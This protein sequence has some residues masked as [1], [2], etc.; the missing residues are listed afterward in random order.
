MVVV[1][2]YK[3]TALSS[4]LI[5]VFVLA[6]FAS[7]VAWNFKM[8]VLPVVG[9]IIGLAFIAE[10]IFFH[11]KLT[12]V[13]VLTFVQLL[14]I[15]VLSTIVLTTIEQFTNSDVGTYIA[16]GGQAI[17]I[18][19]II[20]AILGS[21]LYAQGRLWVNVLI[22]YLLYN[23]ASLVLIVTYPMLSYAII[24]AIALVVV[25]LYLA[26]RHF[27]FFRKE[28]IFDLSSIAT[29]KSDTAMQANLLKLNKDFMFVKHEGN[30][31]LLTFHDNKNIFVLL[32]ISPEKYFTIIK[33][34][35]WVDQKV[36]TGIFE[37]MIKESRLLSRKLK[38]NQKYIVP[39]IYVSKSSLDK[40]VTT[41]KVRAKRYPE[42]LMGRVFI[43]NSNGLPKVLNKYEASDLLPLKVLN[44]LS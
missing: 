24:S 28:T 36:V 5:A 11:P 22:S 40:D 10:A 30:E 19:T 29:T 39:I 35:A 21:Y 20:V 2:T 31:R 42:R 8:E 33:N 4:R 27:V 3:K 14:L 41:L 38:I 1:K 7:V 34:D 18:F 37:L 17:G 6:G 43:V 32:P 44:K 26:F 25:I 16:V 12:L 15:A 9:G 13:S 23:A